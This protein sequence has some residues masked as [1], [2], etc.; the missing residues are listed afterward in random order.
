MKEAPDVPNVVE[1][2]GMENRQ[3]K[4]D[5][6]LEQLEICEKALQVYRDIASKYLYNY[7]ELPGC[8]P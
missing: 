8:K 2:C 1:A 6:L 7:S 3:H 5:T 4:L